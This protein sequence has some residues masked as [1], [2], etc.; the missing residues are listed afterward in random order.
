MK[1]VIAALIASTVLGIAGLAA[2]FQAVKRAY[3]VDPPL[4]GYS[5]ATEAETDALGQ[6]AAQGLSSGDPA[7]FDEAV[8]IE[9]IA[10]QVLVDSP[11]TRGQR[12]RFVEEFK[13]GIARSSSGSIG[14]AFVQSPSPETRAR[15]LR[16]RVRPDGHREAVL[17]LRVGEGVNYLS[18]IV[19]RDPAGR[20]RIVDWYNYLNGEAGHAAFRSLALAMAGDL[21][22]PPIA[23][24]AARILRNP[25]RP[26]PEGSA[27]L[28]KKMA[29]LR[30]LL[31]A[32]KNRE[33]LAAWKRLPQAFRETRSGLMLR[34]RAAQGL[35]DDE[36]RRAMEDLKARFPNDPSLALS[37]VDAFFM[38]KDFE[39]ALK[40]I[41]TIEDAIGGDPYLA[42]LR[43]QVLWNLGQADRAKAMLAQA[44][45]NEPD[46]I[47]L[48]WAAV[49]LSLWRRD[50]GETAR[51]L[52][53]IES[54]FDVLMGD[55]RG[56]SVYSEF[57]T[58]SEFRAWQGRHSRS[59]GARAAD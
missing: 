52:A 54:R 31:S 40:A 34:F 26:D 27:E 51:L 45:K 44:M 43:T 11:M 46:L 6:R 10:R 56:N 14:K 25:A 49:Q 7:P 39:G 17:R 20:A 42:V 50:H 57:V 47:D 33:A 19:A 18:L 59:A 24:L 35:G 32:G 53:E 55:L 9:A 13:L 4:A 5:E 12:A 8:D 23:R 48:W 38:R 3:Q 29:E 21:R 22:R 1:K 30:S 41:D 2:L 15:L 37:Q 16:S 58:S 28:I 36:Y